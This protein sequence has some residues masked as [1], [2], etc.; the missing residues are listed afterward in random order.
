MSSDWVDAK[1]IAVSDCDSSHVAIDIE[2][3]EPI[4]FSNTNIPYD[5]YYL[6]PDPI[7]KDRF[8]QR[9]Y[10]ALL[11]NNNN[12]I[13]HTAVLPDVAKLDKYH[14]VGH[15]KSEVN[16]TIRIPG[17]LWINGREFKS[18]MDLRLMRQG[19]EEYTISDLKK[20]LKAFKYVQI[21]EQKLIDYISDLNNY[22]FSLTQMTKK[23]YINLIQLMKKEN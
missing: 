20:A 11:E 23:T 2:V 9:T 5:I 3:K 8:I 14:H 16:N 17:E 15:V 13:I 10:T 22:D 12:R 6:I 21:A 1:I 4:C 18:L 7:H 19:D